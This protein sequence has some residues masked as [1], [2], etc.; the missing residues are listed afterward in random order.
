MLDVILLVHTCGVIVCLL[1]VTDGI[2]IR[3]RRQYIPCRH[4][5]RPIHKPVACRRAIY[6][7]RQ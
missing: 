5:R 3:H 4:H 7:A 1:Q 2:C 6:K